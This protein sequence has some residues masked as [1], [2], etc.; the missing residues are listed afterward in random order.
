MTHVYM[1][2]LLKIEI[3]HGKLLVITTW[4]TKICGPLALILWPA[5]TAKDRRIQSLSFLFS[6]K[7]R[8]LMCPLRRRFEKC[9]VHKCCEASKNLIFCHIEKNPEH[10]ISSALAAQHASLTSCFCV[11]W[12]VAL[13]SKTAEINRTCTFEVRLERCPK[14]NICENIGNTWKGRMI[15][16]LPAGFGTKG[17]SHQNGVNCHRSAVNRNQGVSSLSSAICQGSI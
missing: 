9:M 2:Y 14:Q 5:S 10:Y 7:A 13:Q 8:L 1:V 16:G 3:F 6:Q 11:L 12:H 17:R 15:Q 4:Y